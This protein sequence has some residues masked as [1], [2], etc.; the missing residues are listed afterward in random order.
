MGK[1]REGEDWSAWV[2]KFMLK[3]RGIDSSRGGTFKNSKHTLK[4]PQ[5]K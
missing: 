5:G 4:P 3:G 2:H 1:E